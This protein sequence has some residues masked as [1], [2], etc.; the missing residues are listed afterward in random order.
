MF[1]LNKIINKIS[2][3]I[4]EGTDPTFSNIG[5]N[6]GVAK[7]PTLEGGVEMYTVLIDGGE[8]GV[9]KKEDVE[10]AKE[11]FDQLYL[12]NKEIIDALNGKKAEDVLPVLKSIMN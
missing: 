5:K 6:E 10:L 8:M 12:N 1:N 2:S 7:T 11:T 3:P 9:I 4:K